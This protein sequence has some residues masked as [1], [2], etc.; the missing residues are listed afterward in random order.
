MVTE[1]ISKFEWLHFC[2]EECRIVKRDPKINNLK[3]EVNSIIYGPI[4]EE[5][6]WATM[7]ESI[8]EKIKS[9]RQKQ[10]EHEGLEISEDSEDSR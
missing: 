8:F 5:W 9:Y 2:N 4:E 3:S 10:K 7:P 1:Q 6:F